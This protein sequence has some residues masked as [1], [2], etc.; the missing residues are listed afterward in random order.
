MNIYILRGLFVF[1][2]IVLCVWIITHSYSEWFRPKV[3]V[4]DKYTE[5]TDEDRL[6]A[7]SLDELVR[8]YDES[9][10]KIKEYESNK[11]NP[12]VPEENRFTSEPYKS[13]ISLK[14]E[15]Q[16]RES[17]AHQLYRVRYYWI[18]GLVFALTGLIIYRKFNELLGMPLMIVGF[19]EMIA[20]T[21]PT[22]YGR[23]FSS[24][25]TNK[26]LLSFITLILLKIFGYMLSIMKE[27]EG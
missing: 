6:N 10:R 9:Y 15:I 25:I 22:R 27:E 13:E 16:N 7:A 21:E 8:K 3:S 1:A 2:M 17:D 26:L 19:M 14:Y 20:H 18:M 24:L 5:L 4:F 11:A 12:A 23:D